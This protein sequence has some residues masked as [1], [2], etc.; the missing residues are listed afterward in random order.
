MPFL[1]KVC[2]RNDFSTCDERESPEIHFFDLKSD[3]K[4]SVLQTYN[5]F[6]SVNVSILPL[7]Q[8]NPSKQKQSSAL[9]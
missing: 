7:V 9:Q 8:K 3:R 6:C 4:C 5:S 2:N 1:G